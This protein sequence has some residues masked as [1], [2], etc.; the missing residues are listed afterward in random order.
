MC[1]SAASR[2][3]ITARRFSS[4]L[5]GSH[6]PYASSSACSSVKL[7][8]AEARRASAAPRRSYSSIWNQKRDGG[9]VIINRTMGE[10][11]ARG[12]R[13][14]KKKINLH[15][16]VARQARQRSPIARPLIAS[17]SLLAPLPRHRGDFASEGAGDD[18]ITSDGQAD[19]WMGCPR[20]R[21]Q[22]R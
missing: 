14:N 8:F 10:R 18:T 4:T 9:N 17:R 21:Q 19:G 12:E 22:Q 15:S 20:T 16:R 1:R 6:A 5:T 3:S 2:A 13:R 11:R 7:F